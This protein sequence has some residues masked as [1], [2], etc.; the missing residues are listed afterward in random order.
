MPTPSTNGQRDNTFM[1]D[2]GAPNTIPNRL[3][4]DI[5]RGVNTT[6]NPKRIVFLEVQADSMTTN[7]C[8]LDPWGNPYI[9]V[10]DTDF[11]GQIEGIVGISY[12]N[13]VT[14]LNNASPSGNGTFPGTIVGV[15]S[16]GPEPGSTNSFLKSW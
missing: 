10:M 3:I 16:Y 9:I 2:G 1:G 6:N 11:N 14:M 8:Y 5:L 4:F 13:I 7:A 12:T 15:M